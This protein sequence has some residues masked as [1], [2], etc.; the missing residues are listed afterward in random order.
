M[1]VGHWLRTRAG[2]AVLVVS[3]AVIDVL[4]VRAAAGLWPRYDFETVVGPTPE[5]VA[6]H[7]Q[8]VVDWILSEM[9]RTGCPPEQVST[10]NASRLNELPYTWR[11]YPD[12]SLAIGRID[13]EWPL[14]LYIYWWAPNEGWW[15]WAD[16]AVSDADVRRI[17]EEHG[18]YP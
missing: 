5:Q 1:R 14:P 12:G 6:E 2:I 7:C 4:V 15:W 3:S 9:E 17:L 13:K 10:D 16:H 11:Y 8:P 18:Y